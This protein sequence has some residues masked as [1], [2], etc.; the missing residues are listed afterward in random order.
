[1]L[2]HVPYRLYACGVF[3]LPTGVVDAWINPNLGSLSTNNDVSY[4]FGG[5]RE[6]MERGTSLVQLVDEMDDAGVEKG[7]LC[8][9]YSGDGDREWVLT[10][11]D[12]Y[13]ERFGLSHVVDPR[14]GMRS[15][16]L[17]NELVQFEGYRMIRMLGLQTGLYYNDPAYYPVYAKC[18]E[19]GVPVGL[20]VGF[21]GPQVPSKYQDPMPIDDV[22][23]FFPDLTIVLQHGGE[24]WVETCVKLMVKWPNIHYMTSAFA[25]KH[26][27]GAIIDYANTRGADRVLFASDY[28]LL[29]HERCMNEARALPFRDIDRFNKFVAGNAQRL[30]FGR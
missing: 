28:P 27:P 3:D 17:V 26:I 23:A 29:T 25:P 2:T 30:L 16:D 24:P 20:N 10:A 6:R 12:K 21:P 14:N 1:V 13:P 9:G 11:R 22:A 19:L 4:L 8:S 15:V 5:L 18:V 7:V